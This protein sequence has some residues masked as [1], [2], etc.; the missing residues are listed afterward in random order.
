MFAL[1]LVLDVDTLSFRAGVFENE[2]GWEQSS[3]THSLR[4]LEGCGSE[5][6][7]R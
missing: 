4:R 3:V 6:K 2:S 7:L 5:E 1:G